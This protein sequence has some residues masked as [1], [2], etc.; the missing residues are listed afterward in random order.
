[1]GEGHKSDIEQRWTIWDCRGVEKKWGYATNII[2]KLK[3]INLKENLITV[4]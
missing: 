1:M 4:T 2:S 3:K